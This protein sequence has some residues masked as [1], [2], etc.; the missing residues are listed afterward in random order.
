[1]PAIDA[2]PLNKYLTEEAQAIANT[3]RSEISVQ[4]IGS[5]SNRLRRSIK[6][7]L[8]KKYGDI[9]RISFGIQ[10][11]GIFLI[12]GAGRGYGGQKGSSWTNAEGE[13]VRTA[14]SSKGKMG[15]G[16]R[17]ARDFW[18]PTLDRHL[19]IMAKR[20]ADG[21]WEMTVKALNIK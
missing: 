8:G 21:T 20:L 9:N 1:M 5:V 10:R 6:P 11:Y 14:T 12:K 3:L 17:K 4:G 15:T 2:T 19:P 18:N 13:R 16:K 7:K